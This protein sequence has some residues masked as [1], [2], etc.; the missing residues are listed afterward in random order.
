MNDLDPRLLDAARM[1]GGTPVNLS[2]RGFL[3]V[4]AGAL[5]I[6]FGLPAGGAQAKQAAAKLV[7]P[8][9]LSAFLEIRP[10]GG[11]ILQSPFIEGGQ[12]VFSAMAQIVGEELES[13]PTLFTVVSAKPGEDYMIMPGGMRFTGGSMSVRMGYATMRKA[14]ATARLMLMQAA[15]A[16]LDVPLEELT[17][18]NGEVIHA[19]S[20]R[21]LSYGELAAAAA[22]LPAPEDAPLKDKADFTWVGKP[23]PRIDVRDKSTGRAQYGID[24]KVE[25]MVQAAVQHAPRRGQEPESFA[26]EDEVLAMKGVD[27]VHKLPGAV[28]VVADSWWR[29]RQ[30]VEALKV[31]WAEPAADAPDVMPADFSTEAM[32]EAMLQASGPGLEAEAEGDAAAA[33]EKA[34]HVLE[35]VYD[36]PYLAHGQLEPPSAIARFN[37]DGTLDLWAP[38]QAPEMFVAAAAKTAGLEPD[39]VTLHSPTLGGFFGRHFLYGDANPFQQAILLAKATQKPVKLIWS[40]EEEFARDALRPM[41]LARFRAALNDD[42]EPLAFS[43][44]TVGE[45]PGGRWFGFPADKADGT[46][47]E[48]VAGKLYAIP[49]RRVAQIPMKHPPAIGFWRSVGHSMNDF[50]YESFFDEMAEAGGKDPYE[51]RLKLLEGNSRLKTLLEAVGEM[52]GGW[53]RGPFKAEDGT[54]RAR[55][56]AMASPF[57]SEVA[58]IAE[59][60][61]KDGE[62]VVHD[63]WVAIDPGS[64]VNPMTIEAQVNSAVALGLSSALLEEVVYADGEPEARNFDGYQILPPDKMPRV[65]TRIIESGAPMGG[66][67]EPGVPGVPPAV[68][69]AVSV[70]TGRRIRSLPLSKADLSEADG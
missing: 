53:R 44:E 46:A 18:K 64:V 61:L 5:V 37:E 23:L 10:D 43:A 42:G 29:A 69:N 38:N 55:G 70:L 16:K 51:L 27:S 33:L 2:R 24:L 39:Q 68:V 7:D 47:V 54:R 25:G 15:A 4:A 19:A 26:N 63:V 3:G 48:G 30:A 21:S 36:A 20:K 41:G 9:R 12:G 62:V 67:G 11:V 14:G 40:R 60:S 28:A 66:I 57:G 31:E 22:E 13:D 8:A 32:R 45:G 56:V 58:T 50:F 59:V 17:A 34:E 65:H 6:G 35:A 1:A 49:N 52:S